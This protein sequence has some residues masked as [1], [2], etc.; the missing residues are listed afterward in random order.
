[1]RFVCDHDVDVA[2]AA[3]LRRLGHDAWTAANA[4]LS[5]ASDDELTVYAYNQGTA[6]PGVD[7]LGPLLVGQVDLIGDALVKVACLEGRAVAEHPKYRE[8]KPSHVGVALTTCPSIIE[9]G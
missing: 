2:V 9:Q 5:A 3:T 1:M 4:G 7:R 8:W 6:L